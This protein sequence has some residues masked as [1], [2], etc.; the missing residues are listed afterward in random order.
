MTAEKKKS[1]ETFEER[2][3][4]LR[5][6]IDN[7]SEGE[8]PLDELESSFKEGIKLCELCLEDLDRV[9]QSVQTLVKKSD[10]R[11]STEEFEEDE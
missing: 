3:G 8:L 5:E 4:K 1:K 2:F 7:L 9:E 11:F 10:G 6:I